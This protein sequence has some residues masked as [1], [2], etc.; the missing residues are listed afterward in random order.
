MTTPNA[1]INIS[2]FVVLNFGFARTI[3]QWENRDISSPFLRIYYVRK[4][5]AVLHLPEKDLEA[6]AGNIYMVPNYMPHSYDC[7]PGFEFYY[8]FFLVSNRN[9][10]DMFDTYTFPTTVQGNH[11]TELLF[12]NYCNLYPQL[13]LPT[14]TAEAFDKHPSYHSYIKAYMKMADYEKM[15]LHGFVEILMSYFVKHAE[16]RLIVKDERIGR[17][18]GYVM[19]HISEAIT[20]KD[21]ADRACLTESHLVRTFRQGMG[22]TPLQYVIKKKIQHAQTLLLS[23]DKSVQEIGRAVGFRDTS[24]FIRLFKKNIGFAPQEYRNGLIG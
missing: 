3:H 13:N 21:L 18:L 12:E 8:L 10:A 19:E 23:T 5:R 20:V 16:A 7:D 22:V 9:T 14:I 17:L 2:D 1:E 11:A 4:G 6:V 24:Y 15:Q